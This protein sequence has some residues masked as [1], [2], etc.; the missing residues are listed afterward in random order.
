MTHPVIAGYIDVRNQVKEKDFTEA[1]RRRIRSHIILTFVL[2]TLVALGLVLLLIV[3]LGIV[4][5]LGIKPTHALSSHVWIVVGCISM[6]IPLLA[7][8]NMLR[9]ADVFKAKKIVLL[10]RE[11]QIEKRKQGTFLIID[12]PVHKIE[13]DDAIL[14]LI[15]PTVPLRIELAELSKT[16]LCISQDDTN[17]LEK[18]ESEDGL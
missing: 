17:L 15:R 6:L 10:V 1:D 11:F 16:L 2:G 7:Y 5:I 8:R 12:Q 4:Y 9:I 18:V 3:G 14:P 13:I